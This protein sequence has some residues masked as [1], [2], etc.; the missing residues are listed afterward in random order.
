LGPRFPLPAAIPDASTEDVPAGASKTARGAELFE[1]VVETVREPLLVLDA[2][3]RVRIANR[4]FYRAFVTTL[5]A[6][7]G[8][9]LWEIGDHAW[10]SPAL[11]ELL[12][13]IIP[14]DTVVEDFEVTHDFGLIGVRS[15]LLNAQRIAPTEHESAMIL[16][17]IEDV[18]DRRRVEAERARLI[19]ELERSNAELE[20]FAYVASHDLQEPLR[21]ISSFTQLLARRYEGRLD[22][23]AD[24]YI[25]YAVDG[26]VRMQALINDLLAYSRVGRGSES[27]PTEASA[28][29][30]AACSNVQLAIRA[31]GA[32]VTADP[33]PRV[34]ID[35]HELL[36]VFQNL[37][38][39]ALKFRREDAPQIHVS[40]RRD[41]SR[42]VIAVED[43]GI[44][45]EGT[46]L[47]RVFVVF[48]RLH[49][50]ADYP[51]N[52]IGLAICKKIIQRHGGEMWI[53]SQVGRG[54]RFLFSLP[55]AEGE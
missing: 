38:A 22:D 24:T 25:R 48:Q 35:P 31:A 13:N 4:A 5:D 2:D 44:G 32:S 15:M 9:H 39:N 45:I 29:F 1:S 41:G 47:D 8:C 40:A 12:E 33:L 52:G 3:L 51:G 46:Q 11:R 20:R 7:D 36:Q 19:A 37:I 53:E 6:L 27:P 54:S 49:A 21:M 23:K 42:W 14:R 34:R 28:S 30:E 17:A 16:V 18:T 50:A 43:N 26:A 10:D 55:A